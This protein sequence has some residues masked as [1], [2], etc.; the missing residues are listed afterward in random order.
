MSVFKD[1]LALKGT[2]TVASARA[3]TTKPHTVDEAALTLIFLLLARVST[4]PVKYT[5][6]IVAPS[7]ATQ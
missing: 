2:L 6:A 5:T 1:S 7:A 4:N 3:Q